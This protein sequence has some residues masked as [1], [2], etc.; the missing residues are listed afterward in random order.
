M[1]FGF[2]PS[3]MRDHHRVCGKDSHCDCGQPLDCGSPPRMRERRMLLYALLLMER[4]TPAYAGKTALSSVVANRTRDHPRVC[5]KDF[6][7]R[8]CSTVIQGSPPRMRERLEFN[9]EISKRR[10][11]TPAYA[12]KTTNKC[13]YR[14]LQTGSPPRMRERLKIA[15]IA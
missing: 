8:P 12:G 1:S 13:P 10:R 3:A 7:T 14:T 11:I 6:A 5:G 2:L 9:H 15:K 4:I